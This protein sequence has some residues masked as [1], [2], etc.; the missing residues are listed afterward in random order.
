MF[1]PMREKTSPG[2]S[3]LDE[4]VFV[5]RSGQGARTGELLLALEP[6]PPEP[7]LTAG[8][9]VVRFAVLTLLVATIILVIALAVGYA[10]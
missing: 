2:T 8:R 3:V 10:A 5:G 7:A 6:E 1:G 9:R 4:L